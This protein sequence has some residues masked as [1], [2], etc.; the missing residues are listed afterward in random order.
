MGWL[1]NKLCLLWHIPSC[2]D[3]WSGERPRLNIA[4]LSLKLITCMAAVEISLREPCGHG[5]V[6][7]LP[8]IRKTTYGAVNYHEKP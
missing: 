4:I 2:L 5:E 8:Q 1:A 7:Q 3:C 6:R